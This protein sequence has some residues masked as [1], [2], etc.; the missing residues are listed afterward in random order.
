MNRNTKIVQIGNLKIGDDNPIA[1]QSMTNTK[2]IN[3]IVNQINCLADIG[4]EIIR[5][6]VPDFEMASNLKVIKSKIKIPL[7]ADIHF[8]YRLAIEAIK[9][10]ADKIRINPGNIGSSEKVKTVLD[11][12]K[13]YKIPI[14]IG[15][16][17]GSLEKS[18]IEKYNGVTAEGLAQSAL[19]YIDMFN[20]Y[21][22]DNIVLSVKSSSVPISINAYKILS[23]KTHYPLHIGITEAGIDPI[24][25][26]V[27]IG[28]ILSTGIGDTIRVSLTDNPLKEIECAKGILSALELRHFGIEFISCPTC[29]RTQI[30]LI[31]IANEVKER[32]KNFDKKIKVA[33]MGCVVNGP[34]E[35]KDADIG[36]AGGINTGLLFKKGVIIKRVREENLVDE[37][38]KEINLL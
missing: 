27:G 6:A 7:V 21:D 13:Q 1:I 10:G 30:N 2:N 37:L 32:C 8:D 33:I 19:N 25:S 38:I 31:K 29:A 23:Q 20:T 11:C 9:N 12:A 24:K 3:D 34:G 15:V 16:N 14:R 35:A 4:C 5:C 22:F 17:S 28:T 26:S 18:I 36:I